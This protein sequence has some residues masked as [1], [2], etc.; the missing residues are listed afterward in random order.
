[1]IHP[2]FRVLVQRPDLLA[3]HL[4]NY[5]EL[6][7]QETRGA[8]RNLIRAAAAWGLVALGLSMFLVFSGVA[9]M[10]GL[11]HNQF[12]WVLL[13]VPGA[14]LVLAF[15]AFLVARQPVIQSEIT[16]IRHQFMADLQTLGEAGE[17]P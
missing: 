7:Q 13:A 14:C 4:G 12:H 6:L 5:A 8:T 1:M 2:I 15:I 16:E 10:M 3:N 17:R 11:L 9:I